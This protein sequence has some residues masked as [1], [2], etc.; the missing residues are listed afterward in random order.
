MLT[1]TKKMAAAICTVSAAATAAHVSLSTISIGFGLFGRRSSGEPEQQPPLVDQSLKNTSNAA[2]DEKDSAVTTFVLSRVSALYSGNTVAHRDLAP[3]CVF[4]DPAVLSIG[5][6]EIVEVFRALKYLSPISL[7]SPRMLSVVHDRQINQTRVHIQ[8]HQQYNNS[9]E[10]TSLLLVDVD[11]SNMEHLVITRFEERWNQVPVLEF[12][13]FRF[14]RRWNG[15][16]S[17]RLTPVVC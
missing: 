9:V 11:T 14:V 10:L 17:Y 12:L 7:D 5:D 16:V 4:S 3:R 8:L 6:M 13:P 1:A 15:I 2:A